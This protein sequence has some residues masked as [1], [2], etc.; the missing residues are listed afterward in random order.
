MIRRQQLGLRRS[1][2]IYSRPGFGVNRAREGSDRPASTTND[3]RAETGLSAS[4][5]LPARI[6]SGLLITDGTSSQQG[7]FVARMEL[8]QS[9]WL[10]LSEHMPTQ[11][12]SDCQAHENISRP[13][14]TGGTP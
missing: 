6:M 2:K 12:D 1:V 14:I 13:R 5:N 8:Y 3:V 9:T 4:Q 11:I 7:Q 10:I